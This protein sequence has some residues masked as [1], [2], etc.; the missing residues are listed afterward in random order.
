MLT[1]SPSLLVREGG[2]TCKR[3]AA[4]ALIPPSDQLRS[5]RCPIPSPDSPPQSRKNESSVL[6]SG[7]D[8]LWMVEDFPLGL[9]MFIS[10]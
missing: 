8:K 10:R 4:E 3:M 9:G 1:F 7:G 6:Q 2:S 5:V